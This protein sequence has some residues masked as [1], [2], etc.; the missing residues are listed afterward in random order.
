MST[1]YTNSDLVCDS[2]KDIFWYEFI[3][4]LKLS[5]GNGTGMSVPIFFYT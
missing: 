1:L 2:E 4:G 5:F 3:S